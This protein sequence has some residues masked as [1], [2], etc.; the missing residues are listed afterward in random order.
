[1]DQSIAISLDPRFYAQWTTIHQ[2][3]NHD[4][5]FGLMY[6]RSEAA[7]EKRLGIVCCGMHE[8]LMQERAEQKAG[9][10]LVLLFSFSCFSS[11]IS[12]PRSQKRI[13]ITICHS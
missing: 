2:L 11:L 6:C 1:M 8:K 3:Q 13:S 4:L 10:F 9:Q 7:F 12:C 5:A